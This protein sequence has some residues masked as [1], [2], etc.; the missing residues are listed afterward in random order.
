MIA[1]LGLI[2]GR[3]ERRLDIVCHDIDPKRCA[4]KKHAQPPTVVFLLHG[5][6][7]VVGV[8]G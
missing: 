3:A 1:T 2:E 8:T 6:P 7:T 5:G 4:V